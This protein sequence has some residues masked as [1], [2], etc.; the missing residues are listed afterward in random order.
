MVKDFPEIKDCEFYLVGGS[1]RDHLLNR[2]SND[3]DYVVMTKMSF[4]DLIFA[5]EE[6]GGKVFEAKKEFLTIRCRMNNRAID[7]A[8]PRRRY[9]FR[10]KT[11]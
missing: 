4:N 10:W 11:S 3:E 8:Y 1:V 9:L 5:I 7:I 2:K 6:Q